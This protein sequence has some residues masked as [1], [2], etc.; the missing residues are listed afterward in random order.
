MEFFFVNKS[1]FRNESLWLK[2]TLNKVDQ[3]FRSDWVIVV[4]R[5]RK[6]KY[7]P[8][9]YVL[10]NR[11]NKTKC[12]VDY[13]TNLVTLKFY[14]RNLPD[15]SKELIPGWSAVL[16]KTYDLR[17]NTQSEIEQTIYAHLC[18]HTPYSLGKQEKVSLSQNKD[19]F[20]KKIISVQNTEEFS[21]V[22]F[23]DNTNIQI[24][25]QDGLII[26][27]SKFLLFKKELGYQTVCQ[28]EKPHFFSH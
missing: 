27:P 7:K 2:T 14:R 18:C 28:L 22:V 8:L 10:E 12:I 15:L 25:I 19:L 17:L 13:D 26:D 23:D 20:C 16:T 11:R 3:R 6:E 9:K 24:P 4:S 1:T 21:H 5:S